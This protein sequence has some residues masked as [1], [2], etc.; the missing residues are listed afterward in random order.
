MK[1]LNQKAFEYPVVL[2]KVLNEIVISVPDLG[3]WKS[4]R[5]EEGSDTSN[6]AKT[7]KIENDFQISEDVL[8]GVFE[9]IKQTWVYI[10]DHINKKKWIPEPSTFRQTLQKS[11]IKDFTLPEF[12]EALSKHMSISENT[13]RREIK[14]GTIQC[15]Q[16]EG[17]HR[18]IPYQELELYLDR[19]N[20][21]KK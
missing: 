18:R 1:K 4:I 10:D 20:T 11:E 17:G 16:T 12:T 19:R 9:G 21:L 8:M 5:I 15:Y 7:S 13:I 14:R 6:S 2:R 3:Y